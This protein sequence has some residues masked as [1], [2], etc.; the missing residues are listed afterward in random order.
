MSNNSDSLLHF[1]LLLFPI[2][3]CSSPPSAYGKWELALEE[4]VKC[5]KAWG[6]NY[7]AVRIPFRKNGGG[8]HLNQYTISMYV[9]FRKVQEFDRVRYLPKTLSSDIFNLISRAD[10]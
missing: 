2:F 4:G 7:F 8:M 6:D 1:F 9:K 3:C 10:T 5:Y